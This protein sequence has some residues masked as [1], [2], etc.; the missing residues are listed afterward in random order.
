MISYSRETIR[1]YEQFLEDCVKKGRNLAI[2][3][4]ENVAK[5]YGYHS[6]EEMELKGR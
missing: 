6:I 1:L 4:R 2:E 3:D 5:M